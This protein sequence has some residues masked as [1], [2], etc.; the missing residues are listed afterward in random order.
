MSDSSGRYHLSY[1]GEVFN[2][3]E[4]RKE[5]EEK[6]EQFHSES[7]TEVILAAYR[8][9]GMEAF[10]RFNGMWAMAIWDEQEQELLLCRDRFGIKPLYYLD[11]VG[12]FAFASETNQLLAE[13]GFTEKAIDEL[14]DQGVSR[15]S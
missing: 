1:N 14:I 13:L 8:C 10:H 15:R 9:W 12:I 3:L 4:L 5:L 2:F 6:G 11:D 7:D